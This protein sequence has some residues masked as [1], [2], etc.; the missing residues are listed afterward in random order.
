M[1]L[2]LS[3]LEACFAGLVPSIIATR[4]SEGMPN[5]SYLSQVVMVDDRHIALTNQF[6]SKTAANIRSCPRAALLLVDGRTGHQ[7]SLEIE[8]KRSEDQGVLFERVERDI[9][10]HAAQ[11]GMSGVMRLRA[12]EIFEVLSISACE[13]D[14]GKSDD[15]I[16]VDMADLA[17]QSRHLAAAGSTEDLFDR[18][19]EAA[20]AIGGA[21]RAVILLPDSRLAVFTVIGSLGYDVSGV[22]S[23]VISGEGLIGQAAANREIA[24]INDISRI[25][26]LSHAVVTHHRGEHS[27][28]EIAFPEFAG[29]IG[30][31]AIPLLAEET[32][33]GVLF[34]ESSRTFA[35]DNQRCAA[36]QILCDFAAAQIGRP[37]TA[38]SAPRTIQPARPAQQRKLAVTFYS[39]DGSIFIEDD[40]VIKGVAGRLLLY[41]L[42]KAAEEGRTDFTNREIRLAP[43]LQ[44][45]E[46]KDNLETRLI[47][48]K[49]RLAAKD[50]GVAVTNTGRGQ[51]ELTLSGTPVVTR[52]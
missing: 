33:V 3:D 52:M 21:E 40:Y 31:V 17:R 47:L 4:S 39:Y 27:M 14:I 36:L 50:F 16:A 32:L 45:P 18:F 48:L 49:R 1:T 19:L 7:F 9:L 11:V 23:E 20:I 29:A 24:K 43:D 8:W 10:A 5:I 6:L 42:E 22:G 30:Q 46:F 34:L 13:P 35:F 12:L 37:S 41:M 38:S 2:R 44:L 25:H 26:R 51:M 15:A 28:R